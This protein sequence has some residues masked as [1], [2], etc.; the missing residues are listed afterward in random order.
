MMKL[1]K[2]YHIFKFMKL[3]MFINQKIR[4]KWITT[5]ICVTGL[6]QGH[7]RP[8]SLITNKKIALECT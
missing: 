5:L 2:I 1:V 6:G 4:R 7:L 3:M 8:R